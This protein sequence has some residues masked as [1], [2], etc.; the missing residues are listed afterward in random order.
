M[1]GQEITLLRELRHQDAAARHNHRTVQSERE[2]D[3]RRFLRFARSEGRQIA[4][5]SVRKDKVRDQEGEPMRHWVEYRDAN[6]TPV[7][8]WSSRRNPSGEY[9]RKQAQRGRSLRGYVLG[10]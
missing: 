8:R 6:W 9:D 10:T 3:D 7:D 5:K 1:G 4:L 2:Q